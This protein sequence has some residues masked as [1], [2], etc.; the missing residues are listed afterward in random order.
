V[1]YA[2]GAACRRH[3][4][5]E[6]HMAKVFECGSVVPGCEFVLHDEDE[7][8]LMIR[9]VEHMRSMHEVEHVSEHLVTRIRS[10]IKDEQ[11]RK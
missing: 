11:P 10:V 6:V 9:A 8:E 1:V 4:L 5:W 7:S 3:L 2:E